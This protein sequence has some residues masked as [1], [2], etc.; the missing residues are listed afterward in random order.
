MER[1]G[2]H[3]FAAEKF[4]GLEGRALLSALERSGQFLFHGS[5]LGGL[6][7]LE[8]RQAQTEGADGAMGDDG[9]PAVCLTPFADVAVFRAVVNRQNAPSGYRSEFSATADAHGQTRLRFSMSAGTEA[10]VREAGAGTVYV[11]AREGFQ[12]FS[13][14]EFRAHVPVRPIADVPVTSSDLPRYTVE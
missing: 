3:S 8:P 6:R 7:E 11:F 5:P 4:A 10:H 14:M 13:P 1:E 2:N 12:P 9:A